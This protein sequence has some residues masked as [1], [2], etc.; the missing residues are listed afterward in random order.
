MK[1]RGEGI[2]PALFR[3]LLGGYEGTTAKKMQC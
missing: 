1:E 2:F 3:A